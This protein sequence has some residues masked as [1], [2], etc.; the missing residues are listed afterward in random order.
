MQ[1]LGQHTVRSFG[2]EWA[3]FDQSGLTVVEHERWFGACL[4]IL[5]WDFLSWFLILY[6]LAEDISPA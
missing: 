1:N 6:P 3:A 5:P 4:G 2:E